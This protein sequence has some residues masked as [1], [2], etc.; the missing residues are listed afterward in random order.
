MV[1]TWLIIGFTVLT[2]IIAFPPNVPSIDSLRN[3][4][5]LGRLIFSPYQVW[6]R[7]E[8]WRLFTSGFVHANWWHLIINMFVFYFFGRIVEAYFVIIWGPGKGEIL[9]LLFY[10]LSIAAANFPDLLKF[11]DSPYYSALGAS[12]ATSAIIFATILVAPWSKMYIFPIPIP[13]PAIIFGV[14]YLAYEQI[15][16]QRS[17]DNVGHSAHFWGSIFGFVFPILL[18]PGL[19]VHFLNQLLNR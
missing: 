17:A 9:F 2:S 10:I 3:P 15:M 4:S 16:A 5:A 8:W 13:I 19:F 11:K 6:H 7:K 12:G 1:F 14:F 18:Y